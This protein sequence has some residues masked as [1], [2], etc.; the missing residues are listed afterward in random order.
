MINIPNGVRIA[1][2]D[3]TVNLT[4]A[5]MADLDVH[6]RS[7]QGNDNDLFTDIGSTATGGQTVMDTTFDDEAAIPPAF[8][9]LKG[10]A[11]KPELA[12]RLAW[13]DGEDAGGT[14]SLDLHD[15]NANASGGTLISWSIRICEPPPPPA[16]PVGYIFTTVY[17]T[18][19]EANNGGFTHGGSFDEWQYG[20]P[21]T[22]GTTTPNPVAPFN[23]CNSG[24]N[25][26]K[27]DL[28]GTYEINS[29]QDLTSPNISL[30]TVTA[31][32]FVTWA[33]RYQIK[34]ANFDHAFVDAQQAGGAT[35]KRLWEWLDGN[36]IDNVGS[37]TVNIA[38]SAGWGMRSGRADNLAGTI[39][40][41][42]FHLDTES[43]V[44]FAGLAIDDVS[45][46]VCV[47]TGHN[48]FLPITYR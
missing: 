23:T 6:L 18:D 26:W 37:P 40:E 13:F 28:T 9:V 3:V 29:I 44:N 45:V 1:D 30:V 41:L 34:T 19:F 5:L 43:S 48:V 11:L 31:P 14:W 17:T 32:I 25:C 22:V 8:T 27:T 21:N 35:P 36:M 46:Q 38:G 20:L 15:D 39:A 16:C 12:Y 24:T 10:L 4:H 2:L 47:F 42:R 7:P 33:Q